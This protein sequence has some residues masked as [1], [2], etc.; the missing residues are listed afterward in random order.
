MIPAVS[1]VIPVYNALDYARLCLESVYAAATEVTFEVIV[2]DNGSAPAVAAWLAV[3]KECRRDLTV[4]QY[5]RPLGFPKAVNEGVRAAKY[6]FV[7]L[8]NSDSAVTD[9]WLDGLLETLQSGPRIGI[10]SPV[11][12][13]L[14]PGRQL[15]SGR[16]TSNTRLNMIDEPRLLFFF[17]VM[18]RRELWRELGGLNEI[19][20][21]GNY[22]DNEFCLKARMAGW[23]LAINP[24]V[25]VPNQ[26]SKTFEENQI[27]H[28]EWLFRN[29]K[30][31]LE[32]ASE[33][34]RTLFRSAHEKLPLSSTSV[35]V[36]VGKG[37]AAHLSDSIASLAN[38]TV[39]GFEILIV[40]SQQEVLPELPAELTRDL[41]IR[42]VQA[43]PGN[44]G[45]FWNQGIAAASGDYLTYLP[46]GDIYLQYHLEILHGLLREK[47][48]Q[49]AYT[50][51]S[52]AIH[53]GGKVRRAAVTNWEGRL[54]R[55]IHGPWAPVVCWIHH[56]SLVSRGGFRED[57][58]S[59]SEWD[60][61]LRLS[62]DSHPW[63]E[64]GVSCERNRWADEIRESAADA[65]SV[66]DT[67]PVVSKAA[68][69]ER[70]QF[71][72][73][74][75]TGIWEETLLVERHELEQ[76]ARRVRRLLSKK[77]T[78][79]TDANVL[80]EARRRLDDVT[81]GSRKFAANSGTTGFRLS[82][83]HTLDRS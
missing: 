75:K 22:E 25:F 61:V 37:A 41:N 26:E 57:L 30:V 53:R 46:S 62:R 81:A 27:D 68:Q 5:D 4:L 63:F 73:A 14:G 49:A 3:E 36:T 1:I 67:F 72:D 64:P 19:Y 31:F 10:A 7:V 38:Q 51:W 33:M 54:D 80:H 21:V 52:V 74:L 69:Q 55:L 34:S 77:Q 76:R 16:P 50:G 20:E 12:D 47:S 18:I 23:R 15:V 70:T 59:F 13:Q 83:H 82:D 28:D 24:N 48:C 60:F 42:Y 56:R 39:M 35:I 78:L 32:R 40:S 43:S 11:S 66:I 9:W 45:H 79:Q 6:D 2:V 65:Q 29:E 44:D 8:L 17:C 71:L 58:A